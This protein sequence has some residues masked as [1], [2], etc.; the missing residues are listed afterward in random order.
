MAVV[1]VATALALQGRDRSG[2]PPGRV[3]NQT[4]SSSTSS[5]SGAGDLGARESEAIAV[6]RRQDRALATGSQ[7]RYL[8]TW[9]GEQEAR[10]HAT[11]TYLNLRALRV[12]TLQARYV[13]PVSAQPVAVQ[14]RFGRT[15]WTADVD[16]SWRLAGIDRA[17]ATMEVTYTFVER[18]GEVVV[19]DIGAASRTP[20]W[21]LGPL[22][23]RRGSGTLVVARDAEDAGELHRG[24]RQAVADVRTVLPRWRGPVVAYAP[25]DRRELEAV[26]AA[27]PGAYSEIAAVTTTVDG[28]GEQDAPVAM[29]VNPEVF[30]RLGPVGARVVLAHESTHVATGAAAVPMP[31]WVAEGFA[32][33]VGVGAVDV[34]LR[35]SARALIQEV[36][37]EGLPRRLPG[38]EAFSGAAGPAEAAYEQAW[39]AMRMIAER[40]G[41][42][43][44]V[45]FYRAV[46]SDPDSLAKAA[47]EQLGVGLPHLT[48]Q[49]RRYLR[50]VAGAG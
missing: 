25:A 17:P 44:L 35:V 8:Q 47:R 16:V 10:R 29:V 27:E 28:S 26:L 24:L 2:T 48:A 46:V 31:L 43:R 6:L 7:A 3:T 42:P 40:Y 38:D 4:A 45:A 34:P 23:V 49:W 41:E 50:S 12:R 36:R 18:S 22:D 11:T 39:L 37:R 15:A 19:A 21:L 20:V 5:P 9:V 14:R 32:D 30:D 33:Y 1:A 13:G